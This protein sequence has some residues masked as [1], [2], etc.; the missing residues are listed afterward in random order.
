MATGTFVLS[1][2]GDAFYSLD[3]AQLGTS[4]LVWTDRAGRVTPF[5]STWRAS[6]EYPALSPDGRTVA[7]SV[8]GGT[9]DLWL[10]RPNGARQK[11]MAPGSANWRP[12]RTADGSAFYFVSVG[13]SGDRNDVAIRRVRADLGA[14]PEL[15]HRAVYGSWEAEVSRDGKWLIIRTEDVD[16]VSKLRYR[17]VTGD[18]SLKPLVVDPG[19]STTIALSPDGRWLACSSHDGSGARY[20]VFVAPF[21][22]MSPRRLVSRDAGTEPRWSRNGRELFFKSGGQ[23]MAANVAQGPALDVS[24]PRAL[25]SLAGYRT[26]RNRQQ[27]DVAP[28]GRFLMIRDPRPGE[29]APVVYVTSWLAELRR[30]VR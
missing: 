18:T 25:F 4:E 7:V 22:S 10:R 24:N 5:D 12:N 3:V 6:F 8:R 14:E 1:A 11:V 9:T 19:S 21:P 15:V 20:D 27:Y 30:A 29:A 26:A 2:S 17:A 16:G 23:M 13:T 28:D